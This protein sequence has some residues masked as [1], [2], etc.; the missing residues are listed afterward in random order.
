MRIRVFVARQGLDRETGSELQVSVAWVGR[1]EVRVRR[2]RGKA[3][4]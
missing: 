2:A 4:R 1:T 3:A